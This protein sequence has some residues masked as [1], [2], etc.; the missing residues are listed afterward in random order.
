[1]GNLKGKRHV[2]RPRSRWDDDVKIHLKEILWKIWTGGGR[3]P[4]VGYCKH[5]SELLG[6][7]KLGENFD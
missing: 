1:L 4:R 2:G 6:N 3:G 7:M 5:G